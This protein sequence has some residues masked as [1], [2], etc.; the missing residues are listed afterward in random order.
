M[1]YLQSDAR[2][3]YTVKVA[4]NE[5]CLHSQTHP[6]FYKQHKSDRIEAFYIV[7]NC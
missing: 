6:V 2:L 1:Y 3:K 5:A 7:D 4:Y